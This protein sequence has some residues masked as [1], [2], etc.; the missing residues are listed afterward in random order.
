MQNKR[1]NSSKKNKT[2]SVGAKTISVVYTDTKKYYMYDIDNQDPTRDVKLFGKKFKGVTA[3]ESK[4]YLNP[5][6][7]RILDD[8]LYSKGR[9]NQEQIEKLPLMRQYYLLEGA[10]K[11]EK[12]LYQWKKEIVSKRID[13]LLLKLF[14]N[15]KI[16]RQLVKITEGKAL[17]HDVNRIDIRNLVSEQ[18]IVARLQQKGLFPKS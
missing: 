16:I 1:S 13:N 17:Y 9:Y 11:V 10:V 15:S 7:R 3:H 8:I 12:E 14:P 6:Q 5:K 4:D 18:Q 2:I